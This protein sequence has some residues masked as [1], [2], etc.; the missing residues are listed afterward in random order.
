MIHQL[1]EEEVFKKIGTSKDGLSSSEAEK[2]L[3]EYGP[4]K[5]KEVKKAYNIQFLGKLIQPFSLGSM[6]S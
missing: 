2:R 3:K 5:L 6:S 4:N 1:P